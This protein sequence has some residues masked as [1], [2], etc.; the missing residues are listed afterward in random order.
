[1]PCQCGEPAFVIL[2]LATTKDLDPDMAARE[3]KSGLT[4][5]V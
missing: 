5:P 3:L 2:S 4:M 1:M